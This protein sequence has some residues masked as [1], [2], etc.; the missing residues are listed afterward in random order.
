M[1]T[2]TTIT[3]LGLN[4]SLTDN[5]TSRLDINEKNNYE[6]DDNDDVDEEE[7]NIDEDDDNYPNDNDNGGFENLNNENKDEN[8]LNRTIIQINSTKM[9]GSELVDNNNNNNRSNNP[10]GTTNSN[11][12]EKKIISKNINIGASSSYMKSKTS[13]NLSALNDRL[14]RADNTCGNINASST[15]ALYS[16]FR[17][18]SEYFIGEDYNNLSHHHNHHHR[19]Q[20]QQSAV[21]QSSQLMVNK[22]I[23]FFFLVHEKIIIFSNFLNMPKLIILN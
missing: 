2:N 8:N 21:H 3:K 14:T 16:Y 4:S 11:L 22:L 13:D 1:S 15:M 18:Q 10:S 6:D 5:E 9:A 20:Q 12:Y 7:E 23:L 17:P 19:H